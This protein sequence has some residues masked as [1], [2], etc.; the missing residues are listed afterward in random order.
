[1][2]L[3]EIRLLDLTGRVVQT[4]SRASKT[5]NIQTSHL[6]EGLY[7]LEFSGENFRKQKSI[8]VNH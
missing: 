4:F 5:G 1:M 3:Q 2:N 7:Y 8:L 6:S